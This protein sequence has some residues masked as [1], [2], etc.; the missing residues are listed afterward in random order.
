MEYKRAKYTIE[1]LRLND[2]DILLTARTEAYVSYCAR[3]S[4]YLEIKHS[5]ES[6]LKLDHVK[7]GLKRMGHPTVWKEMQR[8]SQD[9]A[10]L[11]ILF[12]AAPEA[13]TW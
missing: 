6:P 4:K 2:R 11:K 9:L 3:L 5:N 10:E 1:V 13:M 7:A 8:Q 12:D